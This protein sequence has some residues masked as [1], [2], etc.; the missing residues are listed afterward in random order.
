MNNLREIKFRGKQ[1]DGSWLY[2]S[3]IVYKDGATA[4]HRGIRERLFESEYVI[5]KTV[6]QFTGQDKNGMEVYDGDIVEFEYIIKHPT[7]IKYVGVVKRNKYGHS[8]LHVEGLEYSEF[9][10][11]N[12]KTG[13][14]VGNIHD[15]KELLKTE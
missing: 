9:H 15:N 10:I 4:I 5:T 1:H 3:L 6:G 11:E 7:P 8:Y 14:V 12:L 2:G 13:E